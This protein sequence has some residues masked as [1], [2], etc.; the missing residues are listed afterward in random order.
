[1]P[2]LPVEAKKRHVAALEA[3]NLRS[4]NELG[5]AVQ[6]NFGRV[7][8]MDTGDT[9]RETLIEHL[10]LT[11]V[12]TEEQRLDFEIDFHSRVEER[13]DEEWEKVREAIAEAKKP[14]LQAVKKKN[15]LLDQHGRPLT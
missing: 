3:G 14:K 15:V 13:L 10:V 4:Y 11:G 8:N 6:A 12:W 7:I 5:E 1:M 2:D 9:R